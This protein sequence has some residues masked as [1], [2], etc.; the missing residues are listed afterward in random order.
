[1]NLVDGSLPHADGAEMLVQQGKV[2]R[3]ILV[4]LPWQVHENRAREVKT[5]ESSHFEA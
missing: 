3:R 1:M 4:I 5:L 2:R